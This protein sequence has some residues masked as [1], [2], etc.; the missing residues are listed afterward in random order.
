M[1]VNIEEIEIV[2][3]YKMCSFIKFYFLVFGT[4]SYRLLLKFDFAMITFLRHSYRLLHVLKCNVFRLGLGIKLGKKCQCKMF[5]D[6]RY[7]WIV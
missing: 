7:D 2:K 4:L 6:K 1:F 5:Y 3:F